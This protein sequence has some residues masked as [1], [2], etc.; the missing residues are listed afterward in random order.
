VVKL[1]KAPAGR[2]VK[3][4]P[5]TTGSLP[6]VVT[7][8]FAGK[9]PTGKA[10]A[11]VMLPA[12]KLVKAEPLKAGKVPVVAILPTVTALLA[13]VAAPVTVSVIS[14]LTVTGA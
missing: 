7:T 6:A 5:S 11:P 8:T 14:P 10:F 3:L 13:I 1:A 12:L 9:T 4:E 2:L